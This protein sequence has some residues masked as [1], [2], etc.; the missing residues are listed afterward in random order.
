MLRYN[1]LT[2]GIDMRLT[3]AQIEFFNTQGYLHLKQYANKAFCDDIAAIAQI[4]RRRAIAPLESEEEYAT[5]DTQARR[6]T[7]GIALDAHNNQT[8]RRLRQVYS[9][10]TLFRQWMHH[11][12]IAA[13]LEQIM[14]EPPYLT[15]A[16]HNSIMTKAAAHSTQTRWHQDIRYWDFDRSDL[17]SVWLALDSE[18]SHNGALE[19][20]PQSHTV[21]FEP[22]AF[23]D[24]LYF[25]EDRAENQAFIDSKVSLTLQ[26][27]DVVFFHCKL[28]HRA[29]KNITQKDK[30]SFVY[31]VKPASTQAL[32]G[33]RS[34]RFEMIKMQRD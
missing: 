4:H 8:I 30:Y 3:D 27:G 1:R 21:D 2:K 10:D 5:K 28:L 14:Q 24:R 6:D 11:A 17:V 18:D 7:D 34:E 15:L 23:D 33:S 9:R 31:T 29:N 12:D 20:I 22:E 16:H 19:F 25:K 13:M 32:K 26:K